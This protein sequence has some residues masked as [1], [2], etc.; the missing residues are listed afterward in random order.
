MQVES[1]F[2][3]RGLP[4]AWF[5]T[6]ST[7][8]FYSH[9]LCQAPSTL[10]C[11]CL[12]L[13]ALR[14]RPYGQVL[15]P[16]CTARKREPSTC[17]KPHGSVGNGK[18]HWHLQRAVQHRLNLASCIGRVPRLCCTESG[19]MFRDNCRPV[20]KERSG[21][22]VSR[23]GS[24]YSVVVSVGDQPATRPGWRLLSSLLSA[25]A[26]V[27]ALSRQRTQADG[28]QPAWSARG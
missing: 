16:F 24:R 5:N 7:A 25:E 4:V 14:H 26:A 19:D 20:S 2:T 6:T 12:L 11:T 3:G 17:Q 9:L 18:H 13:H 21:C 23:H 22:D 28:R 1:L 27:L 15:P 8:T 10:A